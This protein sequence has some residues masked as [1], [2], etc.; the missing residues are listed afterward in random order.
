MTAPADRTTTP[1]GETM[2]FDEAVA[3]IDRAASLAELGGEGA[4]RKLLRI[5]HPDVAP[6]AVRATATRVAAKLT[7][8]AGK[9]RTLTTRRATYRLG[10]VIARGDLADLIELDDDKLLKLPR[11]PADND[12]M[13]AEAAALT[14]L[15]RD[16]DPRHRAYAPRLIESFVQEDSAGARREAIVLERLAGFVPLT[17]MLHRLDARDVAWMWRRLL[18]ALGWAHRAGVV[19]GA[20]LP[21]HVL[22]QPEEHGVVLVDW[23]YSVAPGTPVPAVVSRHRATYPPEVLAQ[24]PATAATDIYQASGLMLALIEEPPGAIR[25]FVAG[26]RYRA[27][28]MR[29]QDAW[30]LLAEFDELL[31]K[32]YGPRKFRP[33]TVPAA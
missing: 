30:Q 17:G 11:R 2:T 1:V 3:A 4:Y 18:T 33:F 21:E 29:P 26:C 12:L 31:E 28:R 24:R 22:I 6:A 10:D 27:P 15:D 9:T 13:R 7:G 14:R 8:M 23:C 25:R 16:G 20:V 19:H 5:V 32:W